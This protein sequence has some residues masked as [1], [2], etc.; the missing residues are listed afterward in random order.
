MS[1]ITVPPRS[2]VPVE[3]T[4]DAASIF[5]TDDAWEAAFRQVAESLPALEAFR[6]RLGDGPDVLAD[7]FG[8]MQEVFRLLGHVVVFASMGH[9]ADKTDQAAAARHD[10]ARGLM[11]RTVAA[12]SF[13]DPEIIAVGFERLRRWVTEHTRMA[14][15]AHYLDRL[16]RRA[17]YVRSAEVEELLGQVADPFRT[18]AAT[19]GILADADMVFAPART[20]TGQAVEVAQGN[21]RVLLTHP[22]RELRR[23][24]WESYADTHLA[25]RHAMANNLAAGVKQAVFMARARRYRSA[26]EASLHANDIPLEVFHNLLTA[27]RRHLPTWHRYWRIRRRALGLEKLYIYDERAPLASGEPLVPFGQAVEWIAEGMAPLGEEYV[28]TLRRGVLEQR[29]V[30]VY[31]NRG[32]QSGAFS[33]GA[34]GTHPFILMSYSDDIYSM[35]TLAHEL[36]HSM[37]SHHAWRHQPLVYAR[38][39]LFLAEVASNFN[40]AMV[41]AHLLATRTEPDFQ[42]A[43]IEEAMA[44]FHRYF[45]IMPTLARFELEI[46]ERVERGQALTAGSL[47]GL[48][49]D[50]FR[51]GYGDEVEIDEDRLGITWA[52]FHT[53]LYTSF[54][55]Y[56]YATGISAAH[57]LAG[58]VRQGAPGAA[59]RYLAFLEAGG[60]MYPLEALRLAGVDMATPEPVEEAFEV[61]ARMVGR[62][63]SLLSK[64]GPGGGG[65]GVS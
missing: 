14:I 56:Q 17:P 48:L 39:P 57:V 45:F 27:F 6:G 8:K 44:N 10:R 53:H 22:D 21:L 5:S 3:Y 15:Y 7:W 33:M 43:V 51:E 30:D 50:L 26:L 52:A 61:L 59:D 65:M 63:E 35:S 38:Y 58:H 46:H 42:I 29:W 47:N 16:S 2:A 32:K 13:A 64:V 4:W 20:S 19:H 25:H 11:A 60:S 54:Y 1:T 18:A 34:P 55:V 62:L 49:T 40:Q 12:A 23:T 36:G 37:H 41:R 24:A 28:G 9:A 31:P